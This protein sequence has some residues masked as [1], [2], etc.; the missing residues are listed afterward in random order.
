VEHKADHDAVYQRKVLDLILSKI[1][2]PAKN[3]LFG[4]AERDQ[5]AGMQEGPLKFGVM[6]KRVKVDDAFDNKFVLAH[7]AASRATGFPTAVGVR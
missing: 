7:Y 2:V 6:K 3:G 5:Y 4:F 1:A